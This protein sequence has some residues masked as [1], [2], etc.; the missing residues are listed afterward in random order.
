MRA[1]LVSSHDGITH[2]AERRLAAAD[3]EVV[4]CHAEGA[5][6]FPCIGLA[7]GECPLDGDE[8]IDVAVDV[9]ARSLPQ[10][11]V[12]EIAPMLCALRRRIPAVVTGRTVFHPFEP[13]GARTCD[14]LDELVEV[15][16]AAAGS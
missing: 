1:L 13:W 11:T 6:G 8:R 14:D 7:G 9:R 16:R 12:R 5:P 15:C 4:R 2:D 10:P 3:I